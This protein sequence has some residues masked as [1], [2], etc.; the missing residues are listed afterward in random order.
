MNLQK[1]PRKLL[2]LQMK[3]MKP[4]GFNQLPYNDRARK[5]EF[6]QPWSLNISYVTPAPIALGFTLHRE[7]VPFMDKP[8]LYHTASLSPNK[9]I[10]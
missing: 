5:S 10:Y 2:I 8:A 4:E 6:P 9:H 7:K 3:T 1:G